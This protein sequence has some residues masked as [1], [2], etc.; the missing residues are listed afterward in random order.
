MS[1]CCSGRTYDAFFTERT[2]QRDA[3]RYRRKGLDSTAR[4]IVS[5]VA[6][7]G[8][9]DGEVLDVGGGVGGLGLELPKAGASRA[10]T[11]E[12][13]SSYDEEARRL[14]REAGAQDRVERRVLDFAESA[15]ELAPADAVVMHR[16]VCCY[17]DYE[18]LLAAAAGQARRLLAF[19]FPRSTWWARAGSAV[20]NAFL[21][22]RRCDCRSYVHPPAGLV[23]AVERHGFRL[24]YEHEGPL[25]RIAGFER[26]DGD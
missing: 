5:F 24:A 2:A 8:V 14:A 12:L 15:G 1:G 16:V 6:R 17:P 22:V 11:V 7:R 26:A 21:A 10:V 13:A 20:V 9:R 3:R 18:R 23:A 4:R 19:S 25:W